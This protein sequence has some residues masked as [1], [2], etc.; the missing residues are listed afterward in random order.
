MKFGFA[1]KQVDVVRHEAVAE[2]EKLVALADLLEGLFEEDAGGV[3]V[4][5][6]EILV[7]AEVDCMVVA[8]GLIAL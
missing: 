3:I 4:Q 8:L 5:V 7:A 6:G 1:E 2:Q